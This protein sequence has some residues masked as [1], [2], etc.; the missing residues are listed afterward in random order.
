MLHDLLIIARSGCVSLN[1]IILADIN[2]CMDLSH[3][4][5]EVKALPEQFQ[6]SGLVG[7]Q[8]TEESA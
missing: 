4:D 1:P 5:K 8:V 3:Y 2:V 6:E 7:T